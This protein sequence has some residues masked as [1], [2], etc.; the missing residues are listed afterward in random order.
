[1]LIIINMRMPHVLTFETNVYEH[2]RYI[3]GSGYFFI[4][5]PIYLSIDHKKYVIFQIPYVMVFRPRG[6]KLFVLIR[7]KIELSVVTVVFARRKNLR[8]DSRKR[9]PRY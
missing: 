8:N 5:I 9:K 7:A 3:T 4:L 6:A 1:M 2:L